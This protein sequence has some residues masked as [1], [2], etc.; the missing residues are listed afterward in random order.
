MHKT[1][2][3]RTGLSVFVIIFV[4]VLR[5]NN[6]TITYPLPPL[7]PSIFARFVHETAA[8]SFTFIPRFMSPFPPVITAPLPAL[9]LFPPGSMSAVSISVFSPNPLFLSSPLYGRHG[10]LSD[11]TFLI[12]TFIWHFTI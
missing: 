5:K 11:P 4:Q 10:F 12:C 1:E 7:L 2:Y 6:A 9:S 8:F 3:F